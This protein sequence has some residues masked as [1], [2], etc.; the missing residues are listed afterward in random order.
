MGNERVV[1]TSLFALSLGG[2]WDGVAT[3]SRR[4]PGAIDRRVRLRR[5]DRL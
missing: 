4:D 1:Q 2:R 5:L 3:S